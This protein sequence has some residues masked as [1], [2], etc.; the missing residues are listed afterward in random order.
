[1]RG[2]QQVVPTRR[3]VFDQGEDRTAAIG[4]ELSA[5]FREQPTGDAP[6]MRRTEMFPH[7]LR[8]EGEQVAHLPAF[9]I[10]HPHPSS[11]RHPDRPPFAGRHDDLFCLRLHGLKHSITPSD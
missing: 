6:G 3:R 7:V 1:M 8:G 5:D 10:D 2:D 11:G 4:D 9:N